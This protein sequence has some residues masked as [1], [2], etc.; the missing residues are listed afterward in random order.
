MGKGRAARRK[1]PRRKKRAA[2]K[3]KTKGRFPGDI[4]RDGRVNSADF[5]MARKKGLL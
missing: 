1:P 3:K 2:A 4:N 5:R